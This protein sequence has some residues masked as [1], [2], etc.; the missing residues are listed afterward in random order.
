MVEEHQKAGGLY[1][2]ISELLSEHLPTKVYS[3]SINDSFGESARSSK[4]LR[5]K[6]GLSSDNIFNIVSKI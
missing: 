4:E 3:I 1:S 6:Y 2:L 5:D